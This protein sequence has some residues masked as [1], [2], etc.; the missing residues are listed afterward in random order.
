LAER[1]LRKVVSPVEAVALRLGLANT[2]AAKGKKEKAL[3]L[4]N[5][6]WGLAESNQVDQMRKPYLMLATAAV[7]AKYKPDAAINAF[8]ETIGAFYAEQAKNPAG[9]GI[10]WQ[11]QS[12]SVG[13]SSRL[14]DTSVKGVPIGDI[15]AAIQ[16]FTKLNLEATKELVQNSQNEKV[17]TAGALPLVKELIK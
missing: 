5:E 3:E 1:L 13:Q 9:E 11:G 16:V 4:I 8:R 17:V 6:A 7:L 14:F 15:P 10:N 2:Q 12:V